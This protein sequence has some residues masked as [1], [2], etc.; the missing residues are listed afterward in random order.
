[1]PAVSRKFYFPPFFLPC[2]IADDGSSWRRGAAPAL[3]RRQRVLMETGSCSCAP[4]PTTGPHGDR[5]TSNARNRVS[6]LGG[7]EV[8][9]GGAVE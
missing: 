4:S 7:F 2:S 6:G 1:M 9:Y 5:S 8:L 3:H